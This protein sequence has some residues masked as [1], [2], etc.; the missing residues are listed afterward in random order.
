MKKLFVK[1]GVCFALLLSMLTS[2]TG[3]VFASNEGVSVDKNTTGL[4]D[5]K[6]QATFVFD[7]SNLSKEVDNVQLEGGF[8]FIKESDDYLYEENKG[9]NSGINWYT[10]YEYQDGMYPTG[11]CGNKDRTDVK[12]NGGYILYDMKE[13]N[14]IYSVTLPLP[15]TEY[16]Y[17]Y[18]VTYSDGTAEVVQDPANPSKSNSINGHDATWSYFYVGD[19]SDALKGQEYI[20][21]SQRTGKQVYETYTAYDGTS[22]EVGVYLPA[23]YENG[24]DYKTIYLAHG[25]GG[26]ET[27]WT[28]LGS[29]G[30]IVENLVAEGKLADCVVVSLNNSH[31]NGTGFNTS[32]NKILADDV[33]NNVIPFIE[34]NFK[35]SRKADD[36]AYLG[37]SAG[38]VAS[39]T[40]MELE[41]DSFGAFGI[42]SA[43]AQVEEST[44]TDELIAKLKTKKIYL[45]A[46]TVDFGLINSIFKASLVDFYMPQLDKCG[47]KYTFEKQNGA[48]D[49]NTWRGAFTTFAKDILWNPETVTYHLTID[50]KVT[51]GEEFII[52]TNIPTTKYK[53]LFI[54]EQM[55]S[56]D[57]EVDENGYVMFK[58]S[59]EFTSNLGVGKHNVRCVALNGEANGEF[60]V[61][62]KVVAQN[63]ANKTNKTS[64]SVKTGDNTSLVE[65]TALMF[66]SGYFVLRKRIYLK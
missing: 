3:V 14:Q 48:H 5:A 51:K 56:M 42:V 50:T 65:Y 61:I 25:N 24:Q 43:A 32:S 47:I 66:M 17:G 36:R 22:N 27:E 18:Y 7:A 60:E 19:K 21:P 39:S 15:S 58:L 63:K 45:S 52:K 12:Y 55:V 11:G 28:Q 8:Q 57:Y 64:T 38:G 35:V 37:L 53:D 16:F 34:N 46:G 40:V 31:F 23:G 30:N 20:Y 33:V 2:F 54:D 41:P 13:D 9:S 26:N 1:L 59:K 29:A 6:Y 44:F 62:N 49:W 4:S 10:A